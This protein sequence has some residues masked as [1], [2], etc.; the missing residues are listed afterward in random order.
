MSAKNKLYLIQHVKSSKQG[1][2]ARSVLLK[3]YKMILKI[4]GLDLILVND[5]CKLIQWNISKIQ[6]KYLWQSYDSWN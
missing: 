3:R 4:A 5:F 1:N 6:Q 2:K